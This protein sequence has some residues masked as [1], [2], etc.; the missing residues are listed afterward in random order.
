MATLCKI[1]GQNVVPGTRVGF[2]DNIE[3]S[4]KAV[5]MQGGMLILSVWCSVEGECYEHPVDPRHC[6]IE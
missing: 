5:R 1:E 3:Q 4:G 2:K 6:W